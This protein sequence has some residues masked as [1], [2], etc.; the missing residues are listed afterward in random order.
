[1]GGK[2]L[3]QKNMKKLILFALILCNSLIINAQKTI[4]T[5]KALSF[6]SGTCSA[7][8]DDVSWGDPVESDVK[9]VIT[10]Q[11]LKIYNKAET[12]LKQETRYKETQSSEANIV[13][14]DATDEEQLR[15]KVTIGY[16]KNDNKYILVV[17]YSDV[18]YSF[19]MK[20]V[21]KE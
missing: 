8:T 15:C 4:L 14:F 11:Y 20:L 5:Y 9:I 7:Y 19:Y 18:A 21:S 2:T 12:I 13:S 3:K 16:L 17:K 6:A 1:M 10:G